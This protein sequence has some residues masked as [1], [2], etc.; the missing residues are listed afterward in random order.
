MRALGISY[1]QTRESAIANI[2]KV[3]A[4][5]LTPKRD[6]DAI[7]Q[8]PAN[9][10]A[11]QNWLDGGDRKT[12]HILIGDVCPHCGS[13]YEVHTTDEQ[14]YPFY[15]C[16]NSN[17]TS[18]QDTYYQAA[19]DA[20]FERDGKPAVRYWA[21][22]RMPDGKHFQVRFD[23]K[24]EEG[25]KTIRWHPRGAHSGGKPIIWHAPECTEPTNCQ[26]IFTEGPKAAQGV[27]AAGLCAANHSGGHTVASDFDLATLAGRDVVVWPDNDEPGL[28]GG[29]VLRQRLHKAKAKSVRVIDTDKIPADIIGDA[30]DL[31]AHDV[32]L[33][34]QDAGELDTELLTTNTVSEPLAIVASQSPDI[35]AL[36]IEHV[37]RIRHEDD[38]SE[39]ATYRIVA[40]GTP[41]DVGA[42][43]GITSQTKFRNTYA[44]VTGRWLNKLSS[45]EWDI[46][47]QTL[48]DMRT[49]LFPG[50]P[51]HPRSTTE[52][53]EMNESVRVYFD[54]V[55][56]SLDSE[57]DD[58]E[59]VKAFVSE[60]MARRVSF[61]LDNTENLFLSHFTNWLNGQGEKLSVKKV[62]SR[63]RD[64]GW[65][66]KSVKFDWL[67]KRN[68]R[69]VW[70][71]TQQT[72]LRRD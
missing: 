61:T 21:A 65:E 25:G 27:L 45:A 64:I 8:P 50:H 34:V 37:Y 42:V 72:V 19:K 20:A 49:D 56:E 29:E 40:K 13:S 46:V 43:N 14:A 62:G 35:S 17:C 33:I 68:G 22:Y 28:K 11:Y 71:R 60:Y 38:S 36:G 57:K 31:T 58:I 30:A 53:N 52:T 39:P 69:A 24:L 15:R 67:D 44:E 32:K 70:R 12:L 59:D 55:A 6:P 1:T 54:V 23:T 26:I 2:N 51:A 3:I 18:S 7:T 63:L 5:E 9:V 48:L 10:G 66:P 47:V 16:D 41:I 4:D